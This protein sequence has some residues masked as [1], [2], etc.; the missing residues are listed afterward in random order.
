MRARLAILALTSACS[1]Y[2]GSGD[3]QAQGGPTENVI[4]PFTNQCETF[5]L[6]VG[7]GS[8]APD[9]AQCTSECSGLVEEACL[10]TA[11]CHVTYASTPAGTIFWLCDA[12][13]PYNGDTSACST[14]DAYGCSERDDCVATFHESGAN[15][16]NPS[17]SFESCADEQSATGTGPGSCTGIVSCAGPEPICPSGTVAGIADDCYTGY[18]IPQSDCGPG[19]P[20]TCDASGVR[21]NIAP[22]MCPADTKPGV[23]DGCWSGYCIPIADCP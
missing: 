10:I 14:L 11:D 17:W 19:D 9:W 6:D 23:F 21:C 3:D 13:A 12:I 15:G 18:C 20:G 16:P 7:S 8:A 1:L 2:T 22:P 5:P 4:D